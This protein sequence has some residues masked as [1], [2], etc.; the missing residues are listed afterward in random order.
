MVDIFSPKKMWDL[1][2][3]QKK[4]WILWAAWGAWLGILTRKC[5]FSLSSEIVVKNCLTCTTR[6]WNIALFDFDLAQDVQLD[7]V[8]FLKFWN[9]NSDFCLDQHKEARGGQICWKR[10]STQGLERLVLVREFQW[11]AHVCHWDERQA[12]RQES[13]CCACGQSARKSSQYP[14]ATVFD[15][16]AQVSNLLYQQEL[17]TKK[18]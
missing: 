8:Q 13:T 18:N 5:L 2:W 4:V 9:S 15:R 7:Q 6:T 14:C 10:D 16:W 17:K 11:H 12:R 3:D 1:G